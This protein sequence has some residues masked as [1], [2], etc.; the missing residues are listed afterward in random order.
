MEGAGEIPKSLADRTEE[1][2]EL[3][4]DHLHT[5]LPDAPLSPEE[6]L[7]G[8]AQRT[9]AE[10]RRLAGLGKSIVDDFEAKTREG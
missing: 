8:F 10:Y 1:E 2:V 3:L 9:P 7:L 6:K 4:I 5:D